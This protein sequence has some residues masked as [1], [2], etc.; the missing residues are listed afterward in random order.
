[1]VG[2]DVFNPQHVTCNNDFTCMAMHSDGNTVAVGEYGPRAAVYIFNVYTMEVQAK[3]TSIP[4][5][6]VAAVSFSADGKLL[7]TVALDGY[8]TLSVFEWE[9]QQLV[10]RE[11]VL[12]LRSVGIKQ[13]VFAM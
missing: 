5:E 10:A 12:K 13:K 2:T 1:M 4:P 9:R 7:A 8:A 6:G 11:R 3:L